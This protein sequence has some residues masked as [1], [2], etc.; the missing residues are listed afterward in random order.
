MSEHKEL[1]IQ[2]KK[3]SNKAFNLL[4][5]EYFDLLYG[6][7]FSLTKTHEKTK[8]IVQETF[9]KVW[10]YRQQL[11]PDLSFKAWLYRIARN[12]VLDQVKKQFR[13]P[14][15]EEYLQLTGEEATI[16]AQETDFDYDAFRDSLENAK[17]KLSPRQLEVFK[18]C[19]EEG[20][21]VAETSQQLNVSEQVIYN[22]LSQALKILRKE[23]AN[24]R[25]LFTLFFL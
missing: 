23:M 7:V 25:F 4:Y 2:L 20:L 5:E 24:H 1:V 17:Q 3:G 8:E 11:D 6:F 19:K 9:I 21:S 16:D 10:I 12:Q 14:T 18:L 15:F 22:Y 13:E